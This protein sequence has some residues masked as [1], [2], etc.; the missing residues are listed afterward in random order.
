MHGLVEGVKHNRNDGNRVVIL[1]SA[2]VKKAY[3]STP[4]GEMLE[5]VAD[6]GVT[7]QLYLAIAATY[8]GNESAVLTSDT[9]VVSGSYDVNDGLR[10][11]LG[12]SL[13]RKRYRARYRAFAYTN[14]PGVSL[15]RLELK[16]HMRYFFCAKIF[17]VLQ[18]KCFGE[19]L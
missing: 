13:N 10:R 16:K 1:L 2:D 8:D 12:L 4:R 3:P 18:K 11:S 9:Q 19:N 6:M 5:A 17:C 14:P 7:G 15:N